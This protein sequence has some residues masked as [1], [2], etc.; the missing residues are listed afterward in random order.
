[1]HNRLLV[2]SPNQ[3]NMQEMYVVANIAANPSCYKEHDINQ[4]VMSRT[5]QSVQ[6]N[7][8]INL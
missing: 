3:T 2:Q 4:I 1:M 6:L 5:S 8:F 7:N